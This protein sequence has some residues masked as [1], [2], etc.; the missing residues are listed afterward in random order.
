[1]KKV[2]INSPEYKNI[3]Q[4][5]LGK[6]IIFVDVPKIPVSP[7]NELPPLKLPASSKNELPPLK[8]PASS[9]NELPPLK[10]PV[11]PKKELPKT[12]KDVSKVLSYNIYLDSRRN[13]TYYV[14]DSPI[15]EQD[16]IV[17]HN[18]NKPSRKNKVFYAL[19]DKKK[20]KLIDL[21][22][23]RNEIIKQKRNLGDDFIATE[24]YESWVVE[25]FYKR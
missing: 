1:M 23:N 18:I 6:P 4:N 24:V 25:D 20:N 8:L 3:L 14:S 9:K 17:F 16:T 19:I 5:L 10:L 13:G 11:S 22:S 15:L 2:E 21:T 7:K 12:R